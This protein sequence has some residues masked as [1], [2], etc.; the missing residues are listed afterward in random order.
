MGLCSIACKQSE[1]DAVGKDDASNIYEG[2][3]ALEGVSRAIQSD[4]YNLKLRYDRAEMLY[5]R[6]FYDQ[7]IADL[8]YAIK[9]D[10]TQIEP[11][12]F[13]ADI[14]LDYYRSEDA[15]LTLRKVLKLQPK[16]IATHLKLSEFL[17]ILKNYDKSILAANDVLGIDQNNAEAY[18]MIGMNFRAMGEDQR[19]TNSFQRA[20]ELDAELTDAWIILGELHDQK[21]NPI[22]LQYYSN[23]INVSPD[24]IQALHAKAF[25]LQNHDQLDPAIQLYKQINVLDPQYEDAYFNTGILYMEMDSIPKAYEHFNI[26]INI[27]PENSLAYY[28]RGL[29]YELVGDTDKA[30]NDYQQALNLDPSN[31][32]AK[33][34][35]AAING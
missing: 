30:R 12:H 15:L 23:A 28:F 1:K 10:S 35:L 20:V 4:P 13:L 9:L 3:L 22:A 18:F 29:T 21:N 2:D 19:A 27:D 16:R 6:E 25:Y 33:D 8:E 24:N 5:N 32:K 34:A 14:Y 31:E 11:Y 26:L 17:H 7:A